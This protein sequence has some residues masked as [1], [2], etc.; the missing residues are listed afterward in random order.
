MQ[1]AQLERD[2][3][4]LSK[5]GLEVFSIGESTFCHNIYAVHVGSKQGA[6]LIIQGGMH[7]RE[8]ITSVLVIRLAQYYKSIATYGVYFVP[9]T[10]P[11]GVSLVLDGIDSV[12]D[13]RTKSKL[14]AINGSSDFS[15]WKANGVG[16]D[17][18]TNFDADWGMGASNVN[19]P[20]RESYIGAY[21]NSARET[22]V[23]IQFT[24]EISPQSTISYHSK[25]EVVYYGF[26]G[27]TPTDLARDRKLANSI[28]DRLGYTAVYTTGSAGGYKDW[29][30]RH[31]GIP[32]FTIEVGPDNLK[33]PIGM[34]HLEE[35]VEKNKKIFL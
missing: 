1:Y 32:A 7:A 26:I 13:S 6:Q 27:Q 29:C 34:E 2:I 4:A 12:L 8:W 10:N 23:L 31:L 21:P 11:D 19:H 16:I 18:N 28:A 33:H 14:L 25:G 5:Q 22:E 9:C 15:M 17:I 24:K 30:V 3:L 20:A 35:I